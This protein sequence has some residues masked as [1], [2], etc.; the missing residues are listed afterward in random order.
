MNFSFKN[1]AVGKIIIPLFLTVFFSLPVKGEEV[2][3]NNLE[4]GLSELI[5]TLS[6]SVVSIEIT[7]SVYPDN[8]L[9][10]TEEAVYQKIATGLIYDS[11]G[12]IITAASPILGHTNVYI[13]YEN[14][15]LPASVKAV[16]YQTGLAL[17]KVDRPIG[18]PVKYNAG[19]GCAGEMVIGLGSSIGLRV[20][21]SLG[22]CAGFRG[23]GYIQF[24]AILPSGSSGGGLFNLKGE[25]VGV[26]MNDIL[27]SSQDNVGVAIPI[28]KVDEA[29]D[30]MLA[31]G[32]RM[33]GYLG[34]STAEIE[35]SPPLTLESNTSM[36]SYGGNHTFLIKNGLM[37]TKI[38]PNSPAH[39]A[40]LKT[41][42]ILYMANSKQIYSALELADYIKESAPGTKVEFDLIRQNQPYKITTSLGMYVPLSN[43][44]SFSFYYNKSDGKSTVNDS[45]AQELKNLKEKLQK[46]ESMLL[47]QP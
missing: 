36:A 40:G 11:T 38:V 5:Y 28:N 1:K 9:D 41:G 13:K 22:L 45:L 46:I 24:S 29:V 30:Y 37:I 14:L 34:L 31:S 20:S 10:A 33:A 15:S 2:S 4:I 17:L 26:I 23:D 19:N 6:Q 32:S 21:P 25:L 27:V 7:E 8:R 18:V 47:K 35:I 43:N 39:K 3:L 12:Y 42:D 44:Y 16:D